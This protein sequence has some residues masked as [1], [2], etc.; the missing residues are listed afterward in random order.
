SL[1]DS[2]SGSAFDLVAI[3]QPTVH[4]A[5]GSKLHS[6]AECTL[7]KLSLRSRPTNE[8]RRRVRLG[9]TLSLRVARFSC[10]SPLLA[11]PE[12]PPD[13]A[14]CPSCDRGYGRDQNDGNRPY[15]KGRRSRR[16]KRDLE[17]IDHR[18]EH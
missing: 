18:I 15:R 3:G 10:A 9:E 16:S 17:S 6:P 2:N 8:S 5:S 14:D 7:C 12:C 4:G 1:F 11:D 13:P